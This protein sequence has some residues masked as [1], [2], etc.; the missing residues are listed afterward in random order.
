MHAYLHPYP[1]VKDLIA[2]IHRT[3]L[4]G[5]AA[6][7]AGQDSVQDPGSATRCLSAWACDDGDSGG[8]REGR[9]AG[10]GESGSRKQVAPSHHRDLPQVAR[11]AQPPAGTGDD[12]SR[13]DGVRNATSACLGPE[14]QTE[15][16]GLGLGLGIK[17]W[18]SMRDTIP[19]KYAAEM[20]ASVLAP[21]TGGG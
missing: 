17:G 18:A 4:H 1:Q 15:L 9:Q 19:T 3:T 16:R 12:V 14:G 5:V 10:Q 7:K 21:G 13:S 11:E 6:T 20:P 2:H 8:G